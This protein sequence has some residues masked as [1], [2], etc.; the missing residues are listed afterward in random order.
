MKK[1][2]REPYRGNDLDLPA[3]YGE[4][5]RD[6]FMAVREQYPWM[7]AAEASIWEVLCRLRGDAGLSESNVRYLF[8]CIVRSLSDHPYHCES[9]DMY[10][11]KAE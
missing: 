8:E 1:S 9:C 7:T 3:D 2:R 11:C 4:L 5:T 6:A 10:S